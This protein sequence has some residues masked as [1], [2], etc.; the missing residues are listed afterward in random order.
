MRGTERNLCT[1]FSYYNK[2]YLLFMVKDTP[3]IITGA[4][5]DIISDPILGEI[6]MEAFPRHAVEAIDSLIELAKKN[7]SKDT[8]KTEKDWQTIE[9]IY[10]VF[11]VIFPLS[12]LALKKSIK[13]FRASENPHGI[14]RG[15]GEALIQHQLEIPQPLYTMINTIFANQK[16][17][18]KFV[19][20]IAKVL[21]QLKP[22]ND[23]Y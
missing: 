9:F 11:S 4:K 5:P 10:K 19:K 12:D 8:V 3:N 14:G 18:K 13:E 22:I 2:I 20:G 1:P 17:D 16:W 6:K 23:N 7:K 15:A 21:P